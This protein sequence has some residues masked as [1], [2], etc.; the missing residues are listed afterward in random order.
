[1][2]KELRGQ[3]K[4]NTRNLS[5]IHPLPLIHL[6]AGIAHMAGYTLDRSPVGHRANTE[7]QMTIHTHIHTY[8]QFKINT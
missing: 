4:L 2:N 3:K 8:G 7:R 5:S 6:R 1:M